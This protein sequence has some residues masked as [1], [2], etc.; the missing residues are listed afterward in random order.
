MDLALSIVIIIISTLLGIISSQGKLLERK[1]SGSISITATGWWSLLLVLAVI[2]ASS[3]QYNRTQEAAKMAKLESD[4]DNANRE[5]R[6]RSDYQSSV[7]EITKQQKASSDST[8]IQ[9]KKNYDTSTTNII[10]ALAS[11]GLKYD[12]AKQRIEKIVRDSLRNGPDPVFTF[13]PDQS[14]QVLSDSNHTLQFALTMVSAD[15]GS[16]DHNIKYSIVAADNLAGPYTLLTDTT[17]YRS[18]R[19]L[20]QGETLIRSPLIFNYWRKP[21]LL[22]F[23]LY[24]T[25]KPVS[26]DRVIQVDETR[27]L[28]L[29]TNSVTVII[30]NTEANIKEFVSKSKKR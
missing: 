16:R 18:P 22:F 24:G 2:G 10:K 15:A 30:G 8:T 7:L 25:Y 13:L 12:S 3:L 20:S 17:I 4:I 1:S 21:I 5:S 29:L 28:N 27:V 14:I 23:R 26:S 9:L 19:K 6:I 11:Y